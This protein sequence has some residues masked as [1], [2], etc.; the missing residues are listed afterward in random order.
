MRTRTI[1]MMGAVL[2][3]ALIAPILH[4]AD[5]QPYQEY[6]NRT[7]GA[8]QVLAL[9]DQLFGESVSL[10]NGATDFAQVDISL[11]GNSAVPVQLVRRLPIEAIAFRMVPDKL[12]GAGGWDVDVPYIT[13][14]F[15]ADYKWNID[16]SNQL[17]PRCSW[18]Y[19]YRPHRRHLLRLY[20]SYSRRRKQV[21][22]RCQRQQRATPSGR[23]V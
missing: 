20:D 14:M 22:R 10:Y 23:T 16:V 13:G 7:K 9:S 1:R 12:Y 4:A 2:F 21:V 15:D 8:E 6:A 5:V 18:N 3:A 17:M 11:P 19:T